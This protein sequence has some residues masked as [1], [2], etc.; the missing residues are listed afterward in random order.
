MSSSQRTTGV[1]YSGIQHKD[2]ELVTLFREKLASRGARGILGM[3]RIFKIMDDNHNGT[4]EMSEFWKAIC[5]FRIQ[6]SPE[7]ARQLFDL[8]D[9]NSDG[10][11]DYDELMRSVA[12][13][14]SPFRK[15]MVKKAFD[16]LD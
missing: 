5:D 6:I 4:L 14:M 11:V 15:G 12:G 2:D 7:E 9:I 10:T 13:E 1:T 16:K 3:Q 8:F